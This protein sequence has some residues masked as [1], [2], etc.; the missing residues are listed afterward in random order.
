MEI[1][2]FLLEEK[3]TSITLLV[4]VIL[5]V[6]NIVMDKFKKYTDIDINSV[7]DL[8]ND[9]QLSVVDV[10]ENKERVTGYINNDIHIPMAQVIKQLDKFNKEQ[11]LLI[12]CRSGNRSAHICRLLTKHSFTKVYNLKGG[13]LAWNKANLPIK[14]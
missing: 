7:I 3:I 8:M 10:R 2:N 1:I 13:F 6:V 12:Y 11:P 9:K 14:K 5:L 4:L